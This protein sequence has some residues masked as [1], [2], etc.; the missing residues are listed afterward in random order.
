MDEYVL[1]EIVVEEIP[2]AGGAV[3]PDHPIEQRIRELKE[4][5]AT[6]RRNAESTYRAMQGWEGVKDEGDWAETCAQARADYLSGGFLIERLGG[7]RYLDPAMT[8]TL[9]GL[10]QGVIEDLQI[11]SGSELMLL[12]AAIMSYAYMLRA[13]GWLGDLAMLLEH[14]FFARDC[15]TAQLRAKGYSVQGF[16]AEEHLRRTQERIL[17]LIARANLMLIKNLQAIKELRRGPAPT[18]AV[19][20]AQQVNVADRQVN[21]AN[22]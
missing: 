13:Q 20:T 4:R 22:S 10:R 19:G 1:E 14:D 9:W 16:A 18:I 8:A 12:D 21:V 3:D 17:P 2:D 5:S 11:R 15:P 6:L 7:E